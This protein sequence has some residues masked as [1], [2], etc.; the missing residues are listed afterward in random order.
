MIAQFLEFV[1]NHSLL[2]GAFLV[3]L[4][5]FVANEMRRGGAR[6]SAQEVVNLVNREGAVVVDL[7]ERKE[8]EQGHIVDA[9]NIPYGSLDERLRELEP[10]KDRPIVLACKMGQ[11]AGAAGATLRKAGFA[12]VRRLAGGMSEWRGSSLPV[13]KG[14]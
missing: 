4:A 8:F 13:V 12:D 6:I 7:R 3:L 10:Y 9:I 11:Q 14:S 1:A 2:V 5:L